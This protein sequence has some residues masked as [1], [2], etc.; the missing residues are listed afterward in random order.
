MDGADAAQPRR[1]GA[2]ASATGLTV[3]ALRHEAREPYAVRQADEGWFRAVRDTRI[4]PPSS[5]QVAG[6]LHGDARTGATA[7]C[8]DRRYLFRPEQAHNAAPLV[9]VVEGA[10]HVDGVGLIS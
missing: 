2:A 8:R 9:G 4:I 10:H 5:S 6:Q 7:K 3:R 1:V